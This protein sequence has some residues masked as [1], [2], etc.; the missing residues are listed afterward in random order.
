MRALLT[1][2][3]E[4][5][6]LRYVRYLDGFRRRRTDVMVRISPRA[7]RIA[8]PANGESQINPSSARMLSTD[9]P[10][11]PPALHQ[12]H[13]MHAMLYAERISALESW[14]RGARIA[15][16]GVAYGAFTAEVLEKTDPS[17]FDAYDLF[18]L[19]ERET[20]WGRPTTEIFDNKTQRKFY[21]D[22]FAEPI[23]AGRLRTFE[24]DGATEIAKRGPNAYDVIYID[25]DHTYLGVMR[26]TKAAISVISPR[27]LLVFNDYILYDEGG[28]KYGIVPVVNDLCI[29]HGWRVLYLALNTEMFCDIALARQ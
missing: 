2:Y 23:A 11:P 20:L 1:A 13:V 14:P 27:G 19:H 25:G 3:W 22:R 7:W 24:G 16:I 8:E 15:E 21:E 4:F 26:D 6:T 29:T 5:A 28:H 9:A 10:Y 18:N 12:K 17:L